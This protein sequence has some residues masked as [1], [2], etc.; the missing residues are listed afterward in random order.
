VSALFKS[1][2]V[3]FLLSTLLG[4]TQNKKHTLLCLLVLGAGGYF[5]V[6]AEQQATATGTGKIEIEPSWTL[7][8]Y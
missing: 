4:H 2:Q 1:R 3:K 7:A 5:V 6:R 8:L